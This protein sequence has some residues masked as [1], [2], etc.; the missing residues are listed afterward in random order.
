M[1]L[2]KKDNG[3]SKALLRSNGRKKWDRE[4]EFMD[5]IQTEV[6]EGMVAFDLGANI[7]YVTLVL[8]E[9][10]GPKGHVFAVEPSPRNFEILKRNIELNNYSDRVTAFQMA[11]SNQNKTTKFYISKA[12]NLHSLIPSPHTQ[13]T[14]EVPTK[15]TDD[16]FKDKPFPNFIKMDLEG[17]E[18]E[19]F[20]GMMKTMAKAKPPVKILVEVHPMYYTSERSFEKELQK[21]VD[22]GFRAKYVVSAGIAEPDFFKER[23]YKPKKIYYESPWYRGVYTD[24][25]SR[26][27]ILASNH[28]HTQII[29]KPLK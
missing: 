6:H 12:S 27:M 13:K 24:V 1:F 3:I 14:I 20:Q 11:I 7:G 16:F 29:K 21:M 2:D 17:G 9:L 5:I 18:V 19:A 15:T 22:L 23:G 10:V 28:C 26:D 4:P 25:S 8:S